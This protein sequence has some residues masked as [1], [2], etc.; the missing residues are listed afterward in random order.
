MVFFFGGGD[1]SYA[2]RLSVGETGERETRRKMW[3]GGKKTGRAKGPFRLL[4]LPFPFDFFLKPVFPNL[5]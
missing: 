4:Y 1:A 3:G 5:R 2:V